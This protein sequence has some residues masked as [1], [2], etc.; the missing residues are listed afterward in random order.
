MSERQFLSPTV[1]LEGGPRRFN[2][3]VERLL[4][5]L[6]FSDVRVIDGSGDGGGDI[7]GVRGSELFVF[8][9][10]WTTGQSISRDAVDEVEAAKAKYGA[11]R[12]VV[13]TNAV[14]DGGAT[15]R[16]KRLDGVGVKIEFWTRQHLSKLFDA[17]P[18]Y[19]PSR[20]KLRPYQ[21]EAVATVERDLADKGRALLILATGLGKTVIGGDVICRHLQRSPGDDVLVVAHM[22]DLV[23]QLERALWRHLPKA[24][25]TQVLTGDEKVSE[26]PGVTCATVES[27]LA[28]VYDGYRPALVMVDE[29]HH[30]AEEGLF[31][32]LLDLLSDSKQ[33]G[34][35]ATPWRGDKFDISTRFGEPSYTMGI[36]DGMSKGYLAQVDYRLFVD[37]VDWEVVRDA[38]R[39]DYTVRQLNSKLFLPERDEAIADHLWGV[40][41]ATRNPRAILFCRTIEHAER[42]ASAL[43]RYSPMWRA[44]TCLHS[45]HGKRDRD[46]LLSQFR[47]GRVPI[48]TAVDILNE[49]VDVPDVNII[50]FLRVTHSRRIFVQ[51]LGRGLRLREGK[52]RVVVL[53]FVTDIRRVAAV[54]ALRQD[55][56]ALRGPSEILRLEGP[57]TISFTN[58]DVGSLMEAWIRDAASLE[59]ALDEARLQFPDVAGAASP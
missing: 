16:A 1:L 17:I 57:S 44:T 50:G 59:T 20:F 34:V 24:V 52:E 40:W 19:I 13:V 25:R 6:G 18:D 38:S 5:H 3:A 46:V 48:I 54:L 31:Q 47:L 8:Q 45:K 41:A 33:F 43:S 14:P 55:L 29:T 28:A 37:D 30:V 2:L 12:A 7:L 22:K 53:D 10:K 56:D 11:D 21:E 36:A 35:T 58:Q 27:A 26:L 42:M 51:Q 23:Q 9:N 32:R 4:L 49:G 39:E 15:K